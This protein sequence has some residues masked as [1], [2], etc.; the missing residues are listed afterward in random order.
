[1]GNGLICC[2]DAILCNDCLGC[3][4]EGQCLC[5]EESFCCKMGTDPYG[6]GLKTDFDDNEAKC[7]MLQ[8]ICCECGC[9]NPET[10]I[11]QQNHFC[12]LVNN[13]SIPTNEEIPTTCGCCGFMCL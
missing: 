9:K 6:P 3:S 8:C 5:W 11:M 1:M 4:S 13:C 10:C 2:H 7:C 12:C